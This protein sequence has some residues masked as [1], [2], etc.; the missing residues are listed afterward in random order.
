MRVSAGSK[1]SWGCAGW[2]E[3][4][5]YAITAG[6]WQGQ[7]SVAGSKE[8]GSLHSA[9]AGLVGRKH[10]EKRNVIKRACKD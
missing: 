6:W 4:P 7:A 10:L 2:M 9:A 3:V 8:L 5:P 1:G